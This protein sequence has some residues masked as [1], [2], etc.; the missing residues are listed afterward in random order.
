MMPFPSHAED[1]ASRAHWASHCAIVTPTTTYRSIKSGAPTTRLGNLPAT[2]RCQ[3][4]T[5]G[6]RPDKGRVVA[7]P[8]LRGLFRVR[9]AEL[10]GREKENPMSDAIDRQHAETEGAV[11]DYGDTEGRSEEDTITSDADAVALAAAQLRGGATDVELP[12]APMLPGTATLLAWGYFNPF[13]PTANR[14]DETPVP[15]TGETLILSAS[16]HPMFPDYHAIALIPPG[17]DVAAAVRQALVPVFAINGGGDEWGLVGSVPSYV[18]LIDESPV[19]Y[20]LAAELLRTAISAAG[21]SDYSEEIHDLMRAWQDPWGQAAEAVNRGLEGAAAQRLIAQIRQLE[22]GESISLLD[23]A[24]NQND[25]DD[26]AEMDLFDL[27][28]A[29]ATQHAYV[30]RIEGQMGRAWRGAQAFQSGAFS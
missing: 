15:N 27:W 8:A 6:M 30:E 26:D 7:R 4:S 17:A 12:D 22:A 23:D 14:I 28:F 25:Q 2:A 16:D 9:R 13:G 5:E 1:S 11:D 3:P 21:G 19:D 29:L 10:D 24:E 20:A 18:H